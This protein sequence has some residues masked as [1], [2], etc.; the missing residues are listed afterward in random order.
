M[1]TTSALAPNKFGS[2]TMSLWLLTTS[3]GHGLAGFIIS[4]TENVPNST[5]YYGLGA[6]TVAVAIILFV[7]APWTQRQMADVGVTTQD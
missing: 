1:S 6:V 5:Y 2:Q 7:V 3:T 4:R